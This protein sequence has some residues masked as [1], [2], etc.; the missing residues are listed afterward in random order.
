MWQLGHL[1]LEDYQ[2]WSVSSAL[3]NEFLDLLFQVGTLHPDVILMF[4]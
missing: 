3:A 4:R 2:I 1:S